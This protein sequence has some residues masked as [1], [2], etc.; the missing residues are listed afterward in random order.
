MDAQAIGRILGEKFEGVAGEG[1][2]ALAKLQLPLDAA[3]LDIGT[4]KGYFAIYL[5]SRGYRVLTGEPISDRSKYAGQDWAMNAEKAG[6]RDRIRFEYFDATQLPFAPG[7]FDAVFLFGVLH[8]VPEAQREDV[9]REALR[10]AKKDGAVVF[11]EPRAELLKRLWAEDAGHPHAANP[12][13]YLP[14]ASFLEERLEGALMDIFVYT[15]SA[16]A[17]TAGNATSD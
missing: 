2:L 17:S 16:S 12:S 15:R 9:A 8:H 7:S 6:V 5:A 4:G 1:A 13:R 14:G 11:F 3:I 10:V